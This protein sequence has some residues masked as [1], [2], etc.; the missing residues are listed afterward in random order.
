MDAQWYDHPVA[1]REEME[2]R[3]RQVRIHYGW[4][5]FQEDT[6]DVRPAA[7]CIKQ[8]LIKWC[9]SLN[10]TASFVINKTL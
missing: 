9:C 6:E 10:G 7:C 2:E 5:C 4:R 3:G 1:E 8:I